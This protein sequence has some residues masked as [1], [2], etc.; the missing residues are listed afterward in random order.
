MLLLLPLLPILMTI[1]ISLTVTGAPARVEFYGVNQSIN[2][3][4]KWPKWHSHRKG[5]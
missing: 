2:Q 3:F 4:V 1:A 5:H